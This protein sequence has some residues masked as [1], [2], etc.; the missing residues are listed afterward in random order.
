MWSP[1]MIWFIA[2]STSS[3]NSGS[4][5]GV[6]VVWLEMIGN[7]YR[8]YCQVHGKEGLSF[9]PHWPSHVSCMSGVFSWRVGGVVVVSHCWVL[10]S[11]GSIVPMKEH[12]SWA[13][14]TV[15]WNSSDFFGPLSCACASLPK[16]DTVLLS[17]VI[18]SFQRCETCSVWLLL[19]CRWNWMNRT[20]VK[21]E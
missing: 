13:D 19:V 1:C 5:V 6:A 7:C 21:T 10:G 4:N 16:L 3:T 9:V 8:T 11:Q 15:Y 14:D 17:W 20:L 18:G 12:S 2:S